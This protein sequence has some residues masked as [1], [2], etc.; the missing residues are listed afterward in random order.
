MLMMMMMHPWK[1]GV[2]GEIG[3]GLIAYTLNFN[4]NLL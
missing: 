1:A 2:N 3:T 4:F